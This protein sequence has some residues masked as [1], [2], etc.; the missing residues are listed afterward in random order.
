MEEDKGKVWGVYIKQALQKNVYLHINEIGKQVKQNL[1]NKLYN[2]TIGKCINEGYIK[3]NSINIISYSSGLISGDSV[4]YN[5]VF[6]CM[7]CNPVEGMNIECIVKTITKAGISAESIQ[8]ENGY[9]PLNIFIARD[10]HHTDNYFNNI[11]EEQKIT[12]IVIGSRFELNDPNIVVIGKLK[13]E[14][15]GGNENK[16]IKPAITVLDE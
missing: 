16:H 7:I 14:K 2:M 11:T 15:T 10:H 5:V 13:H 3:P 9:N 12:I 6:D 4:K 1:E 8:G